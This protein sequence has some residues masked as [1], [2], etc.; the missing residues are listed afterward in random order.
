MRLVAS[1]SMVL[2]GMH[3][4][5]LISRPTAR[6]VLVHIS[7]LDVGELGRRPFDALDDVIKDGGPIELF[8]DAREARGPSVDVSAQWAS[9]LRANRE[10]FQH[11]NMLTRSRFVQLT[12]DFVQH[13][14]ELGDRM[15]IFTDPTAFDTTLELASR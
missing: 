12:A 11:I 7:G 1:E 2:D 13:F 15:R 4:T 5:I 9:W 6:T 14:A 3:C 10:H 8:I